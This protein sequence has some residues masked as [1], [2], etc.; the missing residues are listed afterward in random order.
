M[1][2]G[3]GLF[4]LSLKKSVHLKLYLSLYV[5]F[6]KQNLFIHSRHFINLKDSKVQSSVSCQITMEKCQI[7]MK[8]SYFRCVFEINFLNL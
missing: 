4:S 1:F 6:V 5:S 7:T 8:K 3:G 2:A